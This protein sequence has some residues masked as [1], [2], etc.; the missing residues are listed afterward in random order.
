[1]KKLGTHL[2]LDAWQCP[3]EL[4]NDPERIRNSILEAITAGNATLI[5]FCV[6]QFSPHGVTATATLA[7]SHIAI[8][9]WPEYGY[10]AADFFFCGQGEPR[11]A[12]E[13]LKTALQAKQVKLREFKRGFEPETMI[14][15]DQ[16][17]SQV[18]S[19]KEICPV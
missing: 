8:H 10:F 3:A 4:L 9:T 6:H 13:V 12:V 16:V 11:K 18:I 15:S 5:D 1:M 14:D 7:E 17:N 2:I 19:E